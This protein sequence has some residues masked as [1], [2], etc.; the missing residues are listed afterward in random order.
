MTKDDWY[1]EVK[2]L[3][4]MAAGIPDDLLVIL[5]GDMVTEEALPTYQTLLNTFEGCDDP[6]G[7]SDTAWA[8]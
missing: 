1:D 4:E 6:T 3:R 7:D 2:Q 8:R 5:I